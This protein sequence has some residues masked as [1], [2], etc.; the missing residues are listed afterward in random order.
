MILSV[1][2]LAAGQG[3][4]M[5]SDIPKVFHEVGNY[6]MIF[7]V[8]DLSQKLKAKSTTLV[9]SKKLDNPNFIAKAPKEVIEENRRRLKEENSKMNSL[10]RALERLG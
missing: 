10:I 6:P 3:T 7:H 4:R 2:I 8:L 9:I 1:I 5:N